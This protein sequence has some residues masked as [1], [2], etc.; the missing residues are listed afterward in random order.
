MTAIGEVM[1]GATEAEIRWLFDAMRE[2][3]HPYRAE[4][5]AQ[6]AEGP[7]S[8]VAVTRRLKAGEGVL[9]GATPA[10]GSLAYHFRVL[11]D[12]R[13]ILPFDEQRRRGAIEHSYRLS[14]KG[15]KS[16]ARIL[17]GPVR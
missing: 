15:R 14:A 1:I 11:A 7:S 6:L 16:L 3:G 12:D 8:P 5:M 9:I 13:R 10:L 2:S 4:I 17:D